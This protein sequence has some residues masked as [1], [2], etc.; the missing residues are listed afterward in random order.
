MNN[1]RK[2]KKAGEKTFHSLHRKIPLPLGSSLGTK[3][4]F[5][6]LHPLHHPLLPWYTLG[7]EHT[8][9]Q[10]GTKYAI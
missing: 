7:G 10:K 5:F 8:L 6:K 4:K 9:I 1:F 2:K 3:V